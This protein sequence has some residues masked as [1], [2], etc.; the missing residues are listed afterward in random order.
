VTSLP[1]RVS[2]KG[3][4]KRERD[5]VVGVYLLLSGTLRGKKGGVREY[6]LAR[7]SAGGGEKRRKGDAPTDSASVR[8]GG[9]RKAG[10]T[11]TFARRSFLA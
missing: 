4:K 6:H 3:K 2:Q 8:W 7:R 1:A 10:N 11:V 9:S 5:G